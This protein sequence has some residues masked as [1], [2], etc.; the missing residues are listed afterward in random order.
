MLIHDPNPLFHQRSLIRVSNRFLH[1]STIRDP[2]YFSEICPTLIS[3]YFVKTITKKT[4]RT[5]IPSTVLKRPVSYTLFLRTS[6]VCCLTY[7]KKLIFRYVGNSVIMLP[8]PPLCIYLG[9]MRATRKYFVPLFGEPFL[10]PF[11]HVG[12]RNCCPPLHF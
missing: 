8:T 2:S 10:L 4:E 11:P 6:I 3:R 9:N 7:V 5:L 1:R 12:N